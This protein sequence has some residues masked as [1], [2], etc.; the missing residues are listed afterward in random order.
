MELAVG[1]VNGQ[2][3]QVFTGFIRDLTERQEN[4]R[5]M[6]EVH[7]ELV[8]MS[9]LSEMGQM[10][11]ALAHELNQPLTAMG[12]YLSA[13]RQLLVSGNREKAETMLTRA[14]EQ[15]Q[16]AADI[17]RRQREFA[18]KG[19]LERRREFLPKI[20]EE[21]TALALVGAKG[22]GVKVKLRVDPS[23]PAVEIDKI[24][25][26]QVLVNLIRNAVEA[27]SQTSRRE[28][29][30]AA[31]TTGDGQVEI[32]ISDTGPGLPEEIRARLFQPFLT[33]KEGGLGLGLSICRSII[34]AHG[35]ALEAE[36]NPDGGT[37]FRLTLP[38]AAREAAAQ[39]A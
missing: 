32:A 27:M 3:N 19:E 29:V 23:C 26:Q 21:A 17:I 15:S 18:K 6:Q 9:R 12:T 24:Q 1:E 13:A 11:S 38:A 2:G 33:T 22:Q 36:D 4:V 35:G 20:I 39:T 10:A 7:S 25:V 37:T 30:L 34:D 5:R 8:H 28:L 16:R 31:R 14:S